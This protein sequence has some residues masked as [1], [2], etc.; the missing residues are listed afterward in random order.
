[1]RII[2]WFLFLFKYCIFA[3]I[4]T[5]PETA[6]VTAHI[7]QA[8]KITEPSEFHRAIDDSHFDPFSNYNG[9]VCFYICQL[10][11]C[12]IPYLTYLWCKLILCNA[13]AERRTVHTPIR[14]AEVIK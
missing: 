14:V 6:A 13:C 2:F 7:V 9:V 11:F 8:N 12:Y 10:P 1:M 3:P 4:I 5:E